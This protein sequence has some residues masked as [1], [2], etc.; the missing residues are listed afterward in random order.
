MDGVLIVDKEQ[1]YTSFDVV[2]K[3]RGILRMKKIGHGGTLDPQATGVLPVFLGSATKLC[4]YLPDGTK[5]YEAE[6]LFG[7][8]TDT[9]D[10]WGT[11]V[12]ETD[13]TISERSAEEVILSFIGPYEQVPP[14][15]SAK[16]INGKKLYE[17]AR[18]GVS[19]ERKPVS[20][21]ILDIRILSM[22]LPRVR[23]LV[24]CEKGT[25]IRTLCEDIGKKAG[26]AACMSGLRRLRH[27][28]FDLEHAYTLCEIEQAKNEEQLESLILPVDQVLP[29]P[30]LTI[31][32]DLSRLL[33][34]GNRLPSDRLIREL[35]DTDN[36]DGRYKVRDASGVFRGVYR[37]DAG[38]EMLVP[39]KMF[40]KRE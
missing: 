14:M 1:D 2:A 21:K 9:G 20:L 34:N 15:V 37:L 10:I 30:D 6:I 35:P 28:I 32:G 7:R 11:T 38:A 39:E 13:P 16:K 17:L 18:K 19:V 27:G 26:L 40:L 31:P 36:P 22:E 33:M 29:F 5:V 12:S 23:F 4:D 8:S 24:N 3:L 25:Y